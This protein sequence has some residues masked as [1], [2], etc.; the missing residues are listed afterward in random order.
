MEI[1]GVSR[2]REITQFFVEIVQ[3]KNEESESV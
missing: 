3:N 1:K 2:F